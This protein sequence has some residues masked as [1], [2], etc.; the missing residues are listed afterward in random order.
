MSAPPSPPGPVR[1]PC[2]YRRGSCG[3]WHTGRD[4]PPWHHR[5]PGRSDWVVR[6]ESGGR[7]DL[8]WLAVAALR[9]IKLAPGLLKRVKPVAGEALD[10]GDLCRRCI[11]HRRYAGSGGLA[12]E[13]DEARAALTDAA[14]ELRA[15]KVEMVAKDPEKRGVGCDLHLV[16]LAVYLECESAHRLRRLPCGT[17]RPIEALSNPP[18]LIP[19]FAGRST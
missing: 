9:D 14:S 13:V 11:R 4:F 10:G 5:C 3:R 15:D 19:N 17:V 18:A 2:G 6:Q 12:V 1:R 7:H 8:A 16:G